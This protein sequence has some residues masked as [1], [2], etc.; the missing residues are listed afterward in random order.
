M[1]VY[2][3][4]IRDG[5]LSV[6][7]ELYSNFVHAHPTT[8]NNT[9]H[10]RLTSGPFCGSHTADY[11]SRCIVFEMPSICLRTNARPETWHVVIIIINIYTHLHGWYVLRAQLSTTYLMLRW[12]TIQQLAENHNLPQF[13]RSHTS[14]Q[15]IITIHFPA[16]PERERER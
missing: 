14:K 4:F 5:L 2:R 6:V 9:S 10:W 11:Q 15:V 12:G 13:I 7:C 16:G 1:C 8:A 3:K